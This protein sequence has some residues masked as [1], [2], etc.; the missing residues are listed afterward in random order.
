MIFDLGISKEQIKKA[1]KGVSKVTINKCFKKLE[2]MH[3]KL[4][5]KAVL[6][7]YT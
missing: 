6:D 2:P 4:I 7:K 5:P 1:T 3:D